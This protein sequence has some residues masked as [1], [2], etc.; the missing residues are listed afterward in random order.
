[1]A[2][3]CV[4]FN[5]GCSKCRAAKDILDQRGVDAEYRHYLDDAPSVGELRRLLSLLGTDDP[6]AIAR[7][8][9]PRW[10]ELGLDDRAGDDV[11]EAMAA[12]P[13]LIERPIVIRGDHAVIGRPPERVTELL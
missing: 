1:M 7:T 8:G 3:V 12:N 9:E 2:D 6:R 13:V 11:L 5:P 10:Q 4:W